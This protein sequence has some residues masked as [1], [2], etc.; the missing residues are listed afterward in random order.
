MRVYMRNN[1]QTCSNRWMDHEVAKVISIPASAAA[2][3]NLLCR[4]ESCAAQT[5]EQ[6]VIIQRQWSEIERRGH[7]SRSI[8]K[9]NLVCVLVLNSRLLWHSPLLGRALSSA[10]G[11]WVMVF[12]QESETFSL[13]NFASGDFSRSVKL[14]SYSYSLYWPGNKS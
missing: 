9:W 14:T 6:G 8:E 2:A 4:E 10:V 1:Q 12:L 7:L 11:R 13:A 3:C 5:A